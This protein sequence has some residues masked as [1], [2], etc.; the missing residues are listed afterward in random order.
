M[1]ALKLFTCLGGLFIE[2]RFFNADLCSKIRDQMHSAPLKPATV[3]RDGHY[4]VDE[5]VRRS[6]SVQVPQ[7]TKALVKSLLLSLKPQLESHFRLTLTDCEELQFLRYQ[8]GDFFGLH[9]DTKT[10]SNTPEHI[11]RRKVSIVIFLNDQHR[12]PAQNSYGGGALVFYGLLRDPRAAK[13]CFPLVGETGLL[14]AFL[15]DT[16]HEVQPI[17]WGERYTVVTWFLQ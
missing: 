10:D 2:N 12:T 15:S 13:Y 17:I 5:K 14:I 1:D 11:K 8:Q 16:L 3:H 9:T 7:P 4:A 6:Q